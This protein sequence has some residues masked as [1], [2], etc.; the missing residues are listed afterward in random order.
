MQ[1]RIAAIALGL[2]CAAGL[3]RA[4]DPNAPANSPAETPASPPAAT[5]PNPLPAASEAKPAL[6]TITVEARRQLGE[7]VSHFVS[8]VV[9]HY[10]NDSLARWDVP[11][12]PL[13]AGLPRERGEYI[14]WRISQI[15][16]AAHV[17]LAGEKCRPNLYVVVTAQPDL[18]LKKWWRRDPNLYDTGNGMGYVSAFLRSTHPIRGWYNAEL[19]AADGG[20]VTPDALI[21]GLSGAALETMQVPAIQI[22]TATRLEHS[23]LKGLSSVIIVVDTNRARGVTVGQLADYIAMTGLAEI[24]IDADPGSAPSILSL[25][26]PSGKH[27]PGLT[28]WDQALLES[29][30]ATDQAS[31]LQISNIKTDMLKHIAP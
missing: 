7:A 9:A 27:P 14:L 8:G 23:A 12:C 25:F 29:L 21:A 15:A 5:P 26:E 18:L 11:V 30:Y 6:G 17:P 24:R 31:V 20:A 16:A 19:L 1:T 28:S 2:V 3:V 10:G 22:S 13:V 4:Q